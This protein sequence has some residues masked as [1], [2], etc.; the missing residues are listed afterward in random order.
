MEITCASVISFA[1]NKDNVS[2][3]SADYL[4]AAND[5]A[6]GMETEIKDFERIKNTDYKVD[7]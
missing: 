6:T 2:V 5:V 7:P 3:F 4:E 1:P